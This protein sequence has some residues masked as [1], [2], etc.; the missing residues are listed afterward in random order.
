M[1]EVNHTNTGQ[2]ERPGL[3]GQRGQDRKQ[4]RSVP[5]VHDRASFN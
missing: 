2:V 3:Y 4:R 5:G 1:T